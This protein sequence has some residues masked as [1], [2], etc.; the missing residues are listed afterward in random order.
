M[1]CS[2]Y[3]P[4]CLRGESG[5]IAPFTYLALHRF[6]GLPCRDARVVSGKW[7]RLAHM[8]DGAVERRRLAP[9]RSPAQTSRNSPEGY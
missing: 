5:R 8:T 7:L 2:P 4:D 1:V 9:G 3:L 6:L